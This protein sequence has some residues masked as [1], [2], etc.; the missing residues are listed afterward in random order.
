[1]V[2]IG[3][4]TKEVVDLGIGVSDIFTALMGDHSQAPHPF[5]P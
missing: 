4:L 2:D 1:V 3:L 5:L